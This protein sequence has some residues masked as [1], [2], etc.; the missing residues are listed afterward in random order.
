MELTLLG[1]RGLP[2][3]SPERSGPS[4]HLR[5]GGQSVLVD[6]GNGCVRRM[7]EIGED[8]TNLDYIFITHMHSDHTIDLAY[9]LLTGWIRSRR[10]PFTIVGPTRTKD[11]VERLVH[12]YEEDI[13]IRCLHDRVGEDVMNVRVIEV[14]HGDHL[15]GNGWRATALEVEHGHV[16]PA[17]GFVF[18]EDSSKLVIS[19]DTAVSNAIIDAS[20]TANL[21]VHEL[22]QTQ[23]HRG[24]SAPDGREYHEVDQERLTPFARRVAKSH[25]CPHGLADVA[26]R[27]EVPRV[28]T[29][30]MGDVDEPWCR[31]V[32]C[33]DYRGQ[34]TFGEDLM[35]FTV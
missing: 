2:T 1:T 28:V 8:T 32:I 12:A 5:I 15:E 11:F 3:P 33:T 21:L 9:V 10:F 30:H 29:C 4:N 22:M 27:S 16:K 19:G 25:T 7:M 13:R 18:E 14:G 23:P 31:K 35:K 26:S 6:T 24:G 17:L 20:S 34:L